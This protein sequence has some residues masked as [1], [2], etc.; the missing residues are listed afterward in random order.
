MFLTPEWLVGQA[1]KGLSASTGCR[2][3]RWRQSCT[4]A[5]I[6]GRGVRQLG[7]ASWC[8]VSP[9]GWSGDRRGR[10]EARF[11]GC[12]PGHL[13]PDWRFVPQDSGDSGEDPGGAADA[14]QASAG[15]V[16]SERNRPRGALPLQAA[17]AAAAP[18]HE[19]GIEPC[20]G[21]PL[22]DC[23]LWSARCGSRHTRAGRLLCRPPG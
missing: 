12:D 13:L 3:S 4:R 22:V 16:A 23:W 1:C 17:P 5:G 21:L 15:V 20:G 11:G 9:R 19:A 8:R 10:G 2:T 14:S 6:A 7:R 18:S